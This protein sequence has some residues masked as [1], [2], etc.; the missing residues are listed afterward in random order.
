MD[1]EFIPPAVELLE[2]LWAEE[3][4]FQHQRIFGAKWNTYLLIGNVVHE[5]ASVSTAVESYTETLEALLAGG[6][7]NLPRITN[8][9]NDL[10]ALAVPGLP[11][12]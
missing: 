5:H 7:P 11:A 1:E 8:K 3:G 12:W 6:V 10:R 4:A 2:R 9:K